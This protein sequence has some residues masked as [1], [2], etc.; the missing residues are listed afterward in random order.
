MFPVV[1]LYPTKM[2][3]RPNA[4]WNYLFFSRSEYLWKLA[5]II[6]LLGILISFIVKNTNRMKILIFNILGIIMSFITA[7]VGINKLIPSSSIILY[8]ISVALFIIAI[9][10]S[11]KAQV[12]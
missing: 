8:P 3:E 9:I 12:S 5:L 1:G 2:W 10:Y 7:F 11:F 6:L 4:Y